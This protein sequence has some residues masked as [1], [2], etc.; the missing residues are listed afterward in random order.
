[1]FDKLMFEFCT[2]SAHIFHVFTLTFHNLH[3]KG[4][5]AETRESE[6]NY[7]NVQIVR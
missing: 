3:V 1:M 2:L 5:E 6:Y 7:H 4:N